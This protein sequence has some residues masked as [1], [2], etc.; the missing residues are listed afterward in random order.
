[1]NPFNSFD[2]DDIDFGPTP[3]IP[4]RSVLFALTPLGTGT[5]DQESLVS[6]II[7]TSRAHLLN[8]R[9]LVTKVFIEIAPGTGKLATAFFRKDGRTVNG[10]SLYAELFVSAMSKLTGR[11]DLRNLTLHAWTDVFPQ[12]GQGLLAR[13]PKWCP[14]CLTD[15]RNSVEGTRFPLKWF[16]DAYSVCSTHRMPMED[17]CPACGRQQPFFPRYPDQGICHHCRHLLSSTSS[18]SRGEH[19]QFELWAAEAIGD[20]IQRQSELGYAPTFGR[21]QE[22][23]TRQVEAM[24]GGNRAA[25]CRLLGFDN[26]GLR[27]WLDRNERPSFTQFLALC[28]ALNVMPADIFRDNRSMEVTAQLRNPIETRKKRRVCARPSPEK[29]KELEA[30]LQAI[31]ES[32]DRRSV[33]SIATELG[34]RPS[35]LRYWFPEICTTLSE[36]HRQSAKTCAV[37]RQEMQCAR[38]VEIVKQ[39][40]SEGVYPSRRRVTRALRPERISLIKSRLSD[41]YC[42]AVHKK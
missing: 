35:C 23:V 13:H 40:E 25:F 2:D 9:H 39:I 31:L 42:K 17:R 19:S 15:Q 22:F 20:M 6:L 29:R 21:F 37:L 34:V 18:R 26:H 1:M 27:G 32:G 38:I 4:S 30:I 5:S 41:A 3:V 8:P 36:R 24:T 33:S 7:R 16:L 28:Y 10:L 11:Q 12:N 14:V